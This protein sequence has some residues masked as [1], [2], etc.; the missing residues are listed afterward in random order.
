MGKEHTISEI[1]KECLICASP[2]HTPYLNVP[3]RFQLE[4]KFHLVRCTRCGFVYLSPR[5]D[6]QEI[7]EFYEETDYQP[8][9]KDAKSIA[10]KIYQKVRIWNNRY[11]RHL[12]EKY[13]PR[14]IILDYGCGT[15]EFLLEMQN[16]GWKTYGF[17]PADKAAQVARQYGIELLD[18]L[19]H[20]NTPVDAITLWH[21]LEHIHHPTVL[22]KSLKSHLSPNGYLFIA[23]P[24]RLS[25]DARIFRNNWVAFDA[26]R[27][28]YHFRPDDIQSLLHSVGLN[29]LD[30]KGLHFDPWYNTLLSVSLEGHSKNSLK[31]FLAFAKG[32]GV[33]ILA[34][35]QGF[36]FHKKNSSVIYVATPNRD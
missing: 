3:N 10:E 20:L 8:H 29:I 5:P 21:V 19:S 15:G 11:K 35:L 22:L 24:N 33:A 17:E 25:L 4:Q 12:I 23:V 6:E 34:S 27:H 16:A 9:Q 36:L 18:S 13:T 14:G 32:A 1:V 7:L 2:Y 31:K 26:P 30:Y 28:L